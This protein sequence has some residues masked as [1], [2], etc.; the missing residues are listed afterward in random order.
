MADTNEV[1]GNQERMYVLYEPEFIPPGFGLQNTGAICWFNSL[2]QMMLGLPGLNQ[3]LLDN[4]E[5]LSQNKFASEYIK[6]LRA[7]FATTIT[8][9][10]LARAGSALLGTMMIT[11]REKNISMNFTGGQECADEGLV[12]FVE[13]IDCEQVTKLFRNVYELIIECPAC[14]KT[15]STIRDKSIRISLATKI[16]FKNEK[17][18]CDFIRAHPSPVDWYN[19]DCGHKMLNFNR[20]EKLRSLGE[21]VIIMLDKF[22]EKIINWFPSQLAFKSTNGTRLVYKLAGKIEH[23][24]SRH[25]GHYTAHTI[26][27]GKWSCINDSYISAGNPNPTAQTFI[28]AYHMSEIVDN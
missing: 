12:K 14:S 11:A 3:V 24:G 21:I 4:E 9:A 20:R 15:V 27:G 2:L 7:A 8:P 5:S 10:Q 16:K 13:L 19:C 6:I 22:D 18:F 1:A 17:T 26:R 25:S 28:I 23:S